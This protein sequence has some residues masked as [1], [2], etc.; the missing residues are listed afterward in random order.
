MRHVVFIGPGK[1]EWRETRDP[2]LQGP[3]EAI[4]RPIVVGR[5]DL[6]TMY[7]TG[8]MPL[9]GCEPIGHEIIGEMW[10]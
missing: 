1:L 6:D 9:A 3:D 2:L 7:V 10:S 4:V 5:C 8:R